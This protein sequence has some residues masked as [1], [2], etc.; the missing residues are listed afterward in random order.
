MRLRLDWLFGELLSFSFA[1][2]E[3]LTSRGAPTRGLR[4]GSV[5]ALARSDLDS[6]AAAPP[7]GW[8]S[9]E[10]WAPRRSA[11]LDVERLLRI[12]AA[13]GGSGQV[14]GRCIQARSPPLRE[15]PDLDTPSRVARSTGD[16]APVMKAARG[17]MRNVAAPR[18]RPTFPIVQAQRAAS[19]R[20]SDPL[21]K[22]SGAQ[23]PIRLGG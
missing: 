5:A 10:A 4:P 11:G 14:S 8:A 18:D 19:A 3:K 13:N 9:A 12:A 21:V 15:I 20:V 22:R 17:Q 16:A 7:S 1:S 23:C 2:R 6:G